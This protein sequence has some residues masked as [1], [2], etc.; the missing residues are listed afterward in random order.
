MSAEA[1]EPQL[2]ADG[3]TKA[4]HGQAHRKFSHW[5]SGDEHQGEPG[6]QPWDESAAINLYVYIIVSGGLRTPEQPQRHEGHSQDVT[7]MAPSR[8][9]PMYT[10]ES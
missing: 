4:L 5:P 10:F 8:T 7:W 9:F 1:W 6:D 2:A 3:L